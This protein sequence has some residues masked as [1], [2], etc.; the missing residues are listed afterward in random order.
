[1]KHRKILTFFII[2]FCSFSLCAQ[3]SSFLKK[4]D[5]LNK[6][7]RNTIILTESVLAGG[8]LIA[9]NELWYKDFPRSSFH[10]KNDN[11]D[12]KQMDKMGHIM[13]SYYLGKVGME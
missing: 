4:S 5:T 9:L 11:S 1:M 3:N 8:A 13:T 12:W 2:F 7:R 6:K 10:F